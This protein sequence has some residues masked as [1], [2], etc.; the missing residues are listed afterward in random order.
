VD[1]GTFPMNPD[2]MFVGVDPGPIDVDNNKKDTLKK[3]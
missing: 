2:S 3:K 1:G